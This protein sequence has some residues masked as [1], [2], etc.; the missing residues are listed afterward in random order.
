M[1]KKLEDSVGTRPEFASSQM[2]D[3][4]LITAYREHLAEKGKF[5]VGSRVATE[6]HDQASSPATM[7]TYTDAVKEFS[8]NAAAFIEQVPRFTKARDSYEQAMKASAELRKVLDAGDES[9]RT[10][11]AQLEQ[12]ANVRVEKP[13]FDKKKPEP[14]RAETAEAQGRA[15]AAKEFL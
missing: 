5:V 15:N 6:G 7:E 3:E 11:M 12:A 1:W 9:L 8:K 2:E 10:L 4:G 13:A 14:A